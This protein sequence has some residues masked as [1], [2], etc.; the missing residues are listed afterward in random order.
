MFGSEES[1]KDAVQVGTSK[2]ISEVPRR[3]HEIS[4]CLQ[5]GVDHQAVNLDLNPF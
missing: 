3:F 5:V 1:K 4:F 2:M